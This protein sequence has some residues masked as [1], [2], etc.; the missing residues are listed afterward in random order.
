MSHFI[1]Q[2]NNKNCLHE[3][4]VMIEISN[5][6][7][8]D[9][10]MF[11]SKWSQTAATVTQPGQNK[12]SFLPF[13]VIWNLLDGSVILIRIQWQKTRIPTVGLK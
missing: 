5:T 7:I 8:T 4:T 13:I 10:T 1:R 12:I 2:M 11:R 9:A 6:S 3:R